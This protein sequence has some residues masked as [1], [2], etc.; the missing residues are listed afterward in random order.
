MDGA[1][2]TAPATRRFVCLPTYG[3]LCR[4]EGSGG[5]IREGLE[6]GFGGGCIIREG[7]AGVVCGGGGD[8]DGEGGINR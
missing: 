8:S 4:G 2:L 3:F 5:C 6:S 7:V 1:F